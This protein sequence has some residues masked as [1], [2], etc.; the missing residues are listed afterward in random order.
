M[1]IRNKLLA[2]L[3]FISLAP[4][5][6]VGIQFRENLATLGGGLVER[7]FNTLMSTAGTALKRIVEDPAR[8]LRRE[9]QLLES[10]AHF[11]LQDR[12]HH[13]RARASATDTRSCV[14]GQVMAAR[15]ITTS[16]QAAAKASKWTST[17]SRSGPPPDYSGSAASPLTNCSCPS[18][19]P[20]F[21]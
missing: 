5:L 15:K 17:P 3:L 21:R 8:I 10:N 11:R 16:L 7:S 14:R 13:L 1:G 19:K 6:V 4:L 12:G 9:N 2:L 20:E 18:E